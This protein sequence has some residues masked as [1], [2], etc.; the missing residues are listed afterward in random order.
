MKYQIFSIFSLILWKKSQLM[1]VGSD[2]ESR[3]KL[4]LLH[5]CQVFELNTSSGSMHSIQHL[6]HVSSMRVC[7]SEHSQSYRRQSGALHV[8][9]APALCKNQYVI[10][11]AEWINR[12]MIELPH[13]TDFFPLFLSVFFSLS[14]I[15]SSALLI[16]LKDTNIQNWKII[17]YT[18]M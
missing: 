4:H 11:T 12:T 5:S 8:F 15:R 9:N 17:C 14:L 10:S 1:S 13:H 16:H 2:N 18:L 6:L 3:N 7:Y